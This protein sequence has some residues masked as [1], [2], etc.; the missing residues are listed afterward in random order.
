MPFS[1]YDNPD[2]A[3][4]NAKALIDAGARMV[5]IEGGSEHEEVIKD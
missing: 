1:S 4:E 3:L 5:K 2:D